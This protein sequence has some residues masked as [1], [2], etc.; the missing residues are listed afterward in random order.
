MSPTGH[1]PQCTHL[2]TIASATIIIAAVAIEALTLDGESATWLSLYT[3]VD[4]RIA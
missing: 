1:H 3:F 2:T 4:K